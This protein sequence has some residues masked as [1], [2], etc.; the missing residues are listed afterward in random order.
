MHVEARL[1]SDAPL[2]H[3][4]LQYD[5]QGPPDIANVY[6]AVPPAS[7]KQDGVWTVVTFTAETPYLGDRQNSGADFRL[8]LDARLCRIAS[9]TLALE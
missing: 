7:I 9:L 1:Q 6:R 5:A 4:Q 8:F 2:D 3:I